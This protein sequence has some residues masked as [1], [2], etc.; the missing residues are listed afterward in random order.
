MSP[1]RGSGEKK[2]SVLQIC[3]PSGVSFRN[4]TINLNSIDK[5]FILD[6][7]EI[8]VPLSQFLY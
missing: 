5:S 3:H 7:C 8:S 4:S 6:R 2:N 1:L